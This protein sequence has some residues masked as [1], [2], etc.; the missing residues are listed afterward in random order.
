MP[1]RSGATARYVAFL[2]VD[3]IANYGLR[4][5]AS[6]LSAHPSGPSDSSIPKNEPIAKRV[7]Q[8]HIQT[9]PRL[10]TDSQILFCDP[11]WVFFGHK[12]RHKFLD[13]VR[14]E[15]DGRTRTTVA[16]VFRQVQHA[17]AQ[18]DLHVQ[19]P[20]GPVFPVDLKAKEVNIKLLR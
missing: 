9:S 8:D 18:G 4:P 16:A 3:S 7:N 5:G 2:Q 6:N 10:F 15:L 12:L 11:R 13:V 20:F 17:L 19:R 1:P 14:V